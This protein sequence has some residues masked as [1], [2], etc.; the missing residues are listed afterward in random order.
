MSFDKRRIDVTITLGEGQFGEQVG[1]T[2]TLRG[3]R[4]EFECGYVGGA[5]QGQAQINIYGLPLEMINRLTTI[6]P[7][8]NEVMGQNK[9]RV[10]AG[11]EGE[12]L[13]MVFSGSI[14]RAYGQFEQA[15]DVPLVITAYSA[16]V[17]AL[18][19]VGAS[20]Y[21]GSVSVSDIMADFAKEMGFSFEDNGVDAR[22]SNPY[23]SGS[24]LTK[25]KECA[26]AARINYSTDNDVLAIWPRGGHRKGNMPVVSPD[27][28]MIGYPIFG[29]SYLGVKC[30]FR[31]DL[32]QGGLFA[33]Q[34]SEIEKANG[35]WSIRRASH[36]LTSQITN[37]DWFTNV[38]ASLNLN[39]SA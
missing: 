4:V 37:G 16:M 19:P 10:D 22:L 35:Q 13:S 27:N 31:S 30:L 32:I 25:V 12:A 34:G 8:A 23:F 17:A 28:G 33:I 20:S 6:G 26:E 18:K 29:G 9:V 38:V 14:W 15:P 2:V 11:N 21:Q 24:T 1:D 3:H 36:S 7:V 39:G 5:V